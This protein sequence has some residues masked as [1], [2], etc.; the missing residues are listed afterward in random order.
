MNLSIIK[1]NKIIFVGL[2]L[3]IGLIIYFLFRPIDQQ[4]ETPAPVDLG[5]TQQE[6]FLKDVSTNSNVE[7]LT[8]NQ[9]RLNLRPGTN[10]E[11]TTAGVYQYKPSLLFTKENLLELVAALNMNIVKTS[12]SPVQGEVILAQGQNTLITIQVDN[13]NFDLVIEPSLAPDESATL[14]NENIEDYVETARLY[15]E[16][17]GFNLNRYNK[18]SYALKKASPFR[19][20]TVN[21]Q[22]VAD[23]IEIKFTSSI[24]DLPFIDGKSYL[25]PNEI[26][27][28]INTNKDI[29]G[30]YAEDVGEKGDL[31]E[32]V[33]IKNIDEIKND[34]LNNKAKLIN[35]DF[36]PSGELTS[37]TATEITLGY[38]SIKNKIVPVYIVKGLA[39]SSSNY[40]GDVYL[41]LDAQK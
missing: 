41:M 30:V 29:L 28:L 22:S 37:I 3:L 31:I 13:K 7:G 25:Q 38:Y 16:K 1:N 34:L 9:L 27:V 35:V 8:Y 18:I 6:E 24:D 14:E 20:Y 23:L 40:A 17:I 5:G 26:R 15:V 10:V 33:N 12:Q 11:Q 32:T 21:E 36:I 19:I 2:V 4:V 39:K